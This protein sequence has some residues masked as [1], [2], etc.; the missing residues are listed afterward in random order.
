MLH[1]TISHFSHEGSYFS[2]EPQTEGA[3]IFQKEKATINLERYK[4]E[5]LKRESEL[6]GRYMFTQ[7]T[8]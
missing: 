8:L 2:P 6:E 5:N 1:I 7:D 4:T 3:L